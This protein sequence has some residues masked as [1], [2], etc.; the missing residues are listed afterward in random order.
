MS[1][2]LDVLTL[3]DTVAIVEIHRRRW[4]RHDNIYSGYIVHVWHTRICCRR[5][6][7]WCSSWCL[8]LCWR[9]GRRK[10]LPSVVT[11]R[12]WRII[13]HYPARWRYPCTRSS[14]NIEVTIERGLVNVS[15]TNPCVRV[16]VHD[17]SCDS[18]SRAICLCLINQHQLYGTRLTNVFNIP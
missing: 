3:D 13:G 12:M 11:G 6:R 7:C 16:G 15:K 5:F 17:S 18:V 9:H 2:K 4:N 10:L 8:A 14:S 1:F